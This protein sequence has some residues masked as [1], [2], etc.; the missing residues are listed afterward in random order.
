MPDGPTVG[1]YPKIAVVVSG[2]L[3]RLAQLRPGD[4]PILR[5][6]SLEQ[7]IRERPAP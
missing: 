4:R 1:G 7:A 6:V 3:G 5:L 2:D